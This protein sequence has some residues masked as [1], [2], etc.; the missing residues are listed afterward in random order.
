[1]LNIRKMQR[2]P[3]TN[4]TV[5][6]SP[7]RLFTSPRSIHDIFSYHRFTLPWMTRL[8]AAIYVRHSVGTDEWCAISMTRRRICTHVVHTRI[9][10]TLYIPDAWR[11]WYPTQWSMSVQT[12]SIDAFGRNQFLLAMARMEDYRRR[13][14]R[15][16][17]RRDR[18]AGPIVTLAP[19][20]MAR[21]VRD[22]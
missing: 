18:R 2:S 14:A 1:M 16:R 6:K 3:R 22:P 21:N 8:S 17:A 4:V 20:D 5:A 13:N 9:G 12:P 15:V 11:T 7:E 10:G 19:D